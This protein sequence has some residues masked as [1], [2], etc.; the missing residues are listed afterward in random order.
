MVFKR[1]AF[2]RVRRYLIWFS[3]NRMGV[4]K[5]QKKALII[6]GGVRGGCDKKILVPIITWK[7]WSLLFNFHGLLWSYITVIIQNFGFGIQKSGFAG[8]GGRFRNTKS[9]VSAV[10]KSK[11][12][13][14]ECQNLVSS[15]FEC[16]K[17]LVLIWVSKCNHSVFLLWHGLR[18]N[19]FVV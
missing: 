17:P 5:Q 2:N 4:L 10:L 7:L 16:K 1:G 18:N 15:F 12:P 9:K 13:V 19:L 11:K 14:L 3:N 8:F 6:H